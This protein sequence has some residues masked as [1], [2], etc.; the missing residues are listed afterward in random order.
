MAVTGE[1]TQGPAIRDFTDD[2]ASAFHDINA[3]W[4]TAMFALEATDRE[5]LA[6]PRARIIDGG[7]TILFV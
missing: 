6:N 7:G 4:I 3:E 5:V 2:L 1:T